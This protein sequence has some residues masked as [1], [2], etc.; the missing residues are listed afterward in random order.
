M[1]FFILFNFWVL[2]SFVCTRILFPAMNSAPTS[3]S[4][5]R[6]AGPQPA[7]STAAGG[8]VI[9]PATLAAA[10]STPASVRAQPGGPEPEAT[11]R[12]V[13]PVPQCPGTHLR[14]RQLLPSQQV[15]SQLL[16]PRLVPRRSPPRLG[17]L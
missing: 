14:V 13:E 7:P 8:P 12:E 10:P 6:G 5:A 11:P 9:A 4:L 3:E 16:R 1:L 15:E 17:R 2:T